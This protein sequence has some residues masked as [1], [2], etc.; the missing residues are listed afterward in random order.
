MIQLSLSDIKKSKFLRFLCTGCFNTFVSYVSF[1]ILISFVSY[2]F[3]YVMSYAVGIISSY[4]I[5]TIWT[6]EQKINIKNALFYPFVYLIQFSIGWGILKISIEMLE[7]SYVRAYLLS[8]LISIPIG[9]VATSL[10][11]KVIKLRDKSNG[12]N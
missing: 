4:I 9:F 11:F 7:F 10:Y 2:D 5:N 8:I 6:F 3:S 12:S 1:S